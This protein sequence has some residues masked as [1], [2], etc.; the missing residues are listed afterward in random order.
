MQHETIEKN[1][2]LMI[3]LIIV[4]ISFG[5]LVEI[6]PLFFQK[7]TTEP[8]AGL[9][10]LTGLQLEGRDI[11]I[12]EGCN[13][14]HS[15]MI[16]P[17]RAETERYGHFSVAGEF[18]YDHPFL[19]MGDMESDTMVREPSL[20]TKVHSPCWALATTSSKISCPVGWRPSTKA[21]DSLGL[22]PDTQVY[23]IAKSPLL[24]S[25]R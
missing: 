14:C 1:I 22:I 16:R 5:G 17:L 2:G 18:V 25:T 15:Q 19:R 24:K 4:A 20:R 6:V 10:P 23:L 11:Y 21:S 3:V 9:K 8:V 13:V 7:Q 12:R